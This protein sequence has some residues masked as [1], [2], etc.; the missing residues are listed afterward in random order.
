MELIGNKKLGMTYIVEETLVAG[1]ELF[2]HEVKSLRMKL[3][4]LDGARVIVRGGEAFL[5]GAYIAHYQAA[6]GG[7][8]YDVYRTRRLLLNKKEI[9]KLFHIEEEK[10]LTLIP[11]SLYLKNN[12]IKCSLGL[13]KKKEGKDKREDI[14][15]N[16]ARR[17]QRA[18]L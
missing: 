9:Q 15:K 17:E 1:I 6:N 5:V 4:S 7:D 11:T 18:D 14:K 16:I 8:S 13:C 2:G 12:L 10:R 3:G